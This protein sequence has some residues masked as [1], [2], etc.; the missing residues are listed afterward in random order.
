MANRRRLRRATR[1]YLHFSGYGRRKTRRLMRSARR[2]WRKDN[3][4]R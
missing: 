1:R 2:N 3:Y 4:W